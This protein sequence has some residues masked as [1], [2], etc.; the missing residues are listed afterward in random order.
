MLSLF[1]SLSGVLCVPM[2]GE[3]LDKLKIPQMV[4]NNTDSLK[5]AYTVTVDHVLTSTG[6]SAK[7]RCLTI[8]ALADP[9]STFKDFNR[10][11]HIFPL[12]YREG[13]VLKRMG[14][15][16]ASIDLLKLAGKKPVSVISEITLDNG[17]MAR[18]NDLIPWAKQWNLSVITI[19]DLITFIKSRALH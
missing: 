14:H 9:S 17:T 4:E 12:R 1:D 11:G 5:T 7:D 19:S 15:T 2:T 10:P 13:G 8:T 3:I 16:E 6:I 18:R